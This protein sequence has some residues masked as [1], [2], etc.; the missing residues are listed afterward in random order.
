MQNRVI[1]GKVVIANSVTKIGSECNGRIIIGAS[2]GAIYAAYLAVKAGARGIILNDA[3]FAKDNSGVSGANY[4]QDLGIPYG[5]VDTLS[6]CIGDGE[7]VA[8]DGI[9]SFVNL[10]A[11]RLGVKIGM[12]VMEAAFKF[13][14]AKIS[15]LSI[16]E[17]SESRKELVAR[18]G[19]RVV[20][21]VDSASLVQ[22]SDRGCIVVAGSHGGM[23]G[24]DSNSALR[25]E[26]FA[27]FFHDAGKGKDNAGLTRLEPLNNRGIIAGTVSCMSARIGDAK[28][29]YSDGILSN[30][31]ELAAKFGGD[32][33]M[34]VKN[35]IDVL[36][37]K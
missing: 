31:N 33:G 9:I 36:I 37:Y 26:A 25:C 11:E 8:Q 13:C 19:E 20:V 4:C 23:P 21:L 5:A 1:D 24:L 27:G 15:K 12:S 7:S 3:G 10:E 32:V 22:D 30:I 34:P 16:P 2:H 18:A 35:F 28:S 14:E 17:Y 29:I 6:C